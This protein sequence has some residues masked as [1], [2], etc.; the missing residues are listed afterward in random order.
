[1]DRILHWYA[2]IQRTETDGLI[3][4]GTDG[5]QLLATIDSSY[6]GNRNFSSQCG[7]SFHLSP[8]SGAFAVMSKS[9]KIVADSAM[10]IEGIGAHLGVRRVLPYRYF[11]E[12]LSYLQDRPTPLYM[13]NLP[14]IQTIVGER[15]CSPLS[16][17]ILIRFQLMKQAYDGGEIDLEKLASHNMPADILTK[18]L[19]PIHFQR[20]RAVLLGQN[21]LVFDDES[22]SANLK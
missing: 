12:E 3:L 13:D 19:A 5:I 6:Y 11:L 22:I 16:K 1:M 14:F 2:Y 15:G 21:H 20:L 17:H 7:A 18:A 8:T 4:G 10:A 9:P